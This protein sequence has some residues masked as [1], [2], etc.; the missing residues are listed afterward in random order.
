MG[1]SDFIRLLLNRLKARGGV[2]EEKL[3]SGEKVQKIE[4]NFV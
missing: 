1:E 2:V 3:W 4:Y